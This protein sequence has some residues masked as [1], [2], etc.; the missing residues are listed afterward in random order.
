MNIKKKELASA[1]DKLD[2]GDL[3]RLCTTSDLAQINEF[4]DSKMSQKP[5][6]DE[7]LNTLPAFV[8]KLEIR[9][10][11]EFVSELL[12][13]LNGS[14]K[15]SQF[16]NDYQ[17][18][19]ELDTDKHFLTIDRTDAHK[20]FRKA[21]RNTAVH[22]FILKGTNRDLPYYLVRRFENDMK[23]VLLIPQHAKSLTKLEFSKDWEFSLTE[24]F[25]QVLELSAEQLPDKFSELVPLFAAHPVYTQERV[26]LYL[27]TEG[28]R[29]EFLDN[30][31]KALQSLPVSEKS[32]MVFVHPQIAH[33]HEAWESLREMCDAE[34]NLHFMDLPLVSP[35][36]FDTFHAEPAAIEVY[37]RT[38]LPNDM[39]M[40][41]ALNYLELK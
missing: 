12:Q 31:Y 23:P 17:P 18:L 15:V 9:R 4:W 30:I 13:M 5:T 26:F 32:I 28:D 10:Q 38:E 2:L 29:V 25:G 7:V 3:Q 24:I 16:F 39:P 14:Q 20:M 41:S 11:V 35:A 33:S 1:L 27:L 40:E 36:D 37:K 34:P 21:R 8:N 22:V 6:K 19:Y